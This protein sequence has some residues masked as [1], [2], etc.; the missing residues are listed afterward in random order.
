MLQPCTI[1]DCMNFTM[2]KLIS[3]TNQIIK[4]KM[5]K[6]FYW[7]IYFKSLLLW[8]SSSIDIS[9]QLHYWHIFS[10]FLL[11]F[12]LSLVYDS[13]Q[14]RCEVRSYRWLAIRFCSEEK[15]TY[16][17]F[18][19]KSSCYYIPFRFIPRIRNFSASGL[20]FLVDTFLFL[21]LLSQA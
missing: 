14:Q 5:G 1:M 9:L 12:F 6:I 13:Y 19:I 10:P 17:H 21:L 16:F 7:E 3:F 18:D 4:F 20:N 11:P 15:S 2:N 8:I